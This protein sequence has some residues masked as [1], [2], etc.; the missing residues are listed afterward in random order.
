M[1]SRIIPFVI[2]AACRTRE[3][4]FLIETSGVWELTEWS[5]SHHCLSPPHYKEAL[6][7]LFFPIIHVKAPSPALWWCY[8]YPIT[9]KI[10]SFWWNLKAACLLPNILQS[11]I[12]DLWGIHTDRVLFARSCL[13]SA[14]A[15]QAGRKT[16][17]EHSSV[18]L[19]EDRQP[20]LCQQADKDLNAL[21]LC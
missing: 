17:E 6:W 16:G 8:S 19:C 21:T 9:L 5:L 1:C 7:P 15:S 18:A 4:L 13:W 2:R 11:H 14:H 10:T 20:A 3:S 12:S